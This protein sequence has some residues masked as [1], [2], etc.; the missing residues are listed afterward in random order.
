MSLSDCSSAVAMS[1]SSLATRRDADVDQNP[2]GAVRRMHFG[3]G[4]FHS[5][6]SML[7]LGFPNIGGCVSGGNSSGHVGSHL[8]PR[9]PADAELT[10]K[11]HS[12]R[13]FTHTLQSSQLI[14]PLRSPLHCRKTFAMSLISASTDT[15]R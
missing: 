13:H 6:L 1:L 5:S 4:L 12:G 2:Y 15:G 10:S 14:S 8:A 7:D 9:L 3:C 11:P